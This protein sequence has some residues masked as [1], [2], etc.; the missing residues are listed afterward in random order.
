L[1]L[2]PSPQL[3]DRPA[4]RSSTWTAQQTAMKCRRPSR[5]IAPA[6][7]TEA[8]EGY[9]SRIV[10]G[11]MAG[12]LTCSRWTKRRRTEPTGARVA[13]SRATCRVRH[14]FGF[15]AHQVL[16]PR[17]A[18]PNY[19]PD[20]SVHATCP[21]HPV[22]GRLFTHAEHESRDLDR[23]HCRLA[24]SRIRL[25]DLTRAATASCCSAP[26]DECHVPVLLADSG[27]PL[28]RSR[29]VVGTVWL[30]WSPNVC[31]IKWR[32]P[33]RAVR[34]ALSVPCHAGHGW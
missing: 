2:W 26:S 32:I 15:R 13:G 3:V 23:T 6:S 19:K 34:F 28:Q 24:E 30:P 12:K 31:Q 14:D 10:P 29:L 9:K 1:G 5:R 8:A 21:G 25:L 22:I 11:L 16:K 33:G 7:V 4:S 17:A 27:F 18:A 20:S